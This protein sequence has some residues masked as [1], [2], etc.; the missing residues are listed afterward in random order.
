MKG[1]ISNT[2]QMDIQMPQMNSDLRMD[3]DSHPG[4]AF[5]TNE[6][7]PSNKFSA[8][9]AAAFNTHEGFANGNR[10]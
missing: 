10:M 6:N 9:T 8:D 1:I 3:N 7:I 4:V 5:A 2:D